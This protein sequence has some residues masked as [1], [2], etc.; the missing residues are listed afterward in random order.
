MEVGAGGMKQV[1]V[2][3]VVSDLCRFQRSSDGRAIDCR[4]SPH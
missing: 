3:S 1:I 4:M 2:L